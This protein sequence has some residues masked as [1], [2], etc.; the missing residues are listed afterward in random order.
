[1]PAKPKPKPLNANELAFIDRLLCQEKQDA[2]AAY[3]YVYGCSH[4]SASVNGSR[5]IAR[6]SVKAEI[7]RRR[8]ERNVELNLSVADLLQELRNVVTADPRELMEYRRGACRFCH[9]YMNLY[10]RKPSEY[11]ADLDAYK[12]ANASAAAKAGGPALD[13]LGEHFDMQGGIGF[14]PNRKPVKTCPECFGEGAGYSYIKDS[15]TVSKAAARLYAGIKETTA[16]VEIRTRAVDKSVQLLMQNM[17]MLEPDP[18]KG[19]ATAAD[20]AAEVRALL[21]QAGATIGKPR[22]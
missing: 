19:K 4:E 8:K 11:K 16:G 9:G 21:Q 5:M 2:T 15:R 1:M 20:K 18:E 17:G 13:P 3:E 22:A 6:P 12:A 14:N 10:Q 7:A